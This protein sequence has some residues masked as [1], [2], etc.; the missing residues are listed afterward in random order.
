MSEQLSSWK[1]WLATHKAGQSI[2]FFLIMPLGALFPPIG[3]LL[4]LIWKF[5]TR[6]PFKALGV[7]LPPNWAVLLLKGLLF[8]IVL[9]LTF[10]AVIMPPLGADAVNTSFQFIAGRLDMA[11]GLGL[12]VVFAAGICEEVVFR[13]FFFSQ[14]QK[15]LG[16]SRQ[17]RWII[18]F[19]SSLVF[20]LPHLYQGPHGAFQAGLI[21]ILFG[22]I[23]Y[24]KN[25][26][27]WFLM[28]A[29][30]AFDVCSVFLIYHQLETQVAQW[31]W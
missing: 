27:L 16:Q 1:D 2:A 19:S 23:Y 14:L 17:S 6:T 30:A 4:I 8:G 15:W 7:S 20:G 9:K 10:K 13:G 25:G 22:I 26:N 28:I 31:L 24:R 29:H 18:I 3:A 12:Y 5:I 11:L 21:G